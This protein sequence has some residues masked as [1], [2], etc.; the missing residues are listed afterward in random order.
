MHIRLAICMV[1]LDMQWCLSWPDSG[2]NV[3]SASHFG[4]HLRL[5]GDVSFRQNASLESFRCGAGF[6]EDPSLA[7][8]AGLGGAETCSFLICG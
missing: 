6:S 5:I 3:D 1:S 7:M 4:C 2:K 8:L